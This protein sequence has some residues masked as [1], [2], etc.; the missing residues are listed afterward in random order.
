M[1]WDFNCGNLTPAVGVFAILAGL[2]KPQP[3]TT[4]VSVY[5]TNT[6]TILGIEVPTDDYGV[7]V[8][9]GTAR[10]AGVTGTGAP[11]LTN[12][13][14][15]VGASLGGALFPTGNRTDVLTV[16][17]VGDLRLFRSGAASARR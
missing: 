15:T 12:F 6:R 3:G 1:Y 7:P 9:E 4:T 16:P 17:G 2:A 13:S 11:V 8:F 5:Q 10:T 14:R